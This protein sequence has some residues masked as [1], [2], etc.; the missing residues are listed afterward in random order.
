MPAEVNLFYPKE[1]LGV[2]SALRAHVGTVC[3]REGWQLHQ[4]S[5]QTR[6]S[7]KGRPILLV[8]RDVAAGLYPRIHRAPVAVLVVGKDPR[9]PLHP[10]EAEVLRFGKH[11]P[12]KR[13]VDYKSCWI[14]VPNDPGN[15]S[16]V[17][18]FSG[19]CERIECEGEHDPRCVPFHVFS[20]RGADL[21]EAERRREFDHQYGAG[22][23]RVDDNGAQWVLNPRDFHGTEALTV[24]GF[25]LRVGCHWDVSAD[26][27]RVATPVGEWRVDGHVNIYPDAHL[28]PRGSN[29]RK[30]A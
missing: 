29:V 22:G 28:R 16:W 6:R 8:A 25:E 13:F 5:V 14:R 11:V 17:G 20:G 3:Q 21:N 27:W 9:V 26:N 19:W 2:T 15:D 23:S 12:L 18:T 30:L 10:L 1:D 24:G 4:R 7:P